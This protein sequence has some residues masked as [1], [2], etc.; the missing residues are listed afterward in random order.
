MRPSDDEIRAYIKGLLGI[1]FDTL[2]VED[3]RPREPGWFHHVWVTPKYKDRF[4]STQFLDWLSQLDLLC[5][6]D[7]GIIKETDDE[8]WHIGDG[9]D[10]LAV[11]YD[12]GRFY[13]WLRNLA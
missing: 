13:F 10:S 12:K 11:G 7:D 9:D 1:E 5:V 3:M 6:T 2:E 8:V 4:T